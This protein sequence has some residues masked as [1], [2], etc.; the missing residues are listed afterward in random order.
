MLMR[1]YADGLDLKSRWESL[2]QQFQVDRSAGKKVFFE[3]VTAYCSECRFYHTLA[4]I[5]Q[6]LNTIEGMIGFAGNLPA[7]QFA[8]WFHDSIYDSKAQDNE[9]RSAEY[10]AAVLSDLGVPVGT[11]EAVAEM[12]LYTKRH[13][14]PVGDTDSYILLDADLAILGADEGEY[15]LYA[16]GIRREYSW[17]SEGEYRRGRIRVLQKFLRRERIYYTE[18]MFAELEGR[19]RRNIRDEIEGLSGDW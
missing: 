9:E 16:E 8:A 17:L 13:E 18:R 3:L 11:V 10:A 4:H 19:A 15:R 7:I 2:L 5:Q 12:I 14:A 6:V 1:G